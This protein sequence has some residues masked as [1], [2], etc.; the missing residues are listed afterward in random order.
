VKTL[1][2]AHRPQVIRRA[3]WERGVIVGERTTVKMQRAD[4]STVSVTTTDPAEEAA[5]IEEFRLLGL[6]DQE[7]ELRR[8]AEAVDSL[9]DDEM[10]PTIV[11]CAYLGVEYHHGK[12][13]AKLRDVWG[14]TATTTPGLKRNKGVRVG[15][16]RAAKARG[17]RAPERKE[18][19]QLPLLPLPDD[20]TEV[21]CQ[22]SD[23]E[24]HIAKLDAKRPVA[25]LIRD[26]NG[27]RFVTLRAEE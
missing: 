10:V 24:T 8:C 19:V 7:E 18:A 13:I 16:L 22:I 23:V 11:A 20:V 27:T 14:L 21:Y 6:A 12:R 15:D 5:A 25:L 2:I 3:V 17:P 26:E 9:A 4:G 1:N